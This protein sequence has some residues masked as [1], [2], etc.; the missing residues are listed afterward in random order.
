MFHII[1]NKIRYFK[2][3]RHVPEIKDRVSSILNDVCNGTGTKIIDLL[4]VTCTN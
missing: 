1:N 2:T 3:I 4:F